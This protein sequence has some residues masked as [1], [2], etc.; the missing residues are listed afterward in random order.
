M[1]PAAAAAGR[2]LD[3]ARLVGRA[4]E[5]WRDLAARCDTKLTPCHPDAMVV[6]AQLAAAYLAA[7][8][9]GEAVHRYQRVLAVRG[10]ELAPGHPALAADRVS[11]A[12]ALIMA[13]EPATRSPSCN[14]PSANASSSAV[15]ATQTPSA[16]GTS[17]PPRTRPQ[18]K[19]GWQSSC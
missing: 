10:R 6:A 5:Y 7:G 8:Y 17:W 11:L 15:P 14:R 1:P 9:A 13:D 16:S 18:A 3:A 12:K 4:V 2:S 19:P